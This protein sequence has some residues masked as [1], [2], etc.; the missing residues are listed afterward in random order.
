MRALSPEAFRQLFAQEG[1]DVFL[2][3]LTLEHDDLP[4][5]I[6]LVKNTEDLVRNAGTFAKCYFDVRLAEDAADSPPQVQIVI[7][8]IDKAIGIA[9]Q[10]LQ[11]K[12][13]IT[14]DVVLASQP[15]TVEISQGFFL[16]NSTFNA[17]A[18]TGTLGY[19]EEVLN[20]SFPQYTYT[21]NNTP[22]LWR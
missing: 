21:P 7:D 22:G 16:L 14:L 19:E 2:L 12:V 20:Q 18:I 13:Q 9:L 15:N 8:N 17:R 1:T 10:T 4:N 5:P 3:C 11:G 6:R